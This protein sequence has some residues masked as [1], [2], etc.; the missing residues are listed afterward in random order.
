MEKLDICLNQQK[1]FRKLLAKMDYERFNESW[2]FMNLWMWWKPYNIKAVFENDMIACVMHGKEQEWFLRPIAMKK[3]LKSWFELTKRIT[4]LEFTI[5]HNAHEELIDAFKGHGLKVQV[6]DEDVELAE[7]FYEADTFRNYAGKKLQKKRNLVNRFKKDH[8]GNWEFRVLGKGDIPVVQE[9]TKKWE[10][11]N[12]KDLEYFKV[13]IQ[14][15]ND[16]LEDL[17]Q[18]DDFVFGGIFIGGKIEGFSLGE[19][20]GDDFININIEKANSDI[21]GL[22][23]VLASEFLKKAAPNVKYVSR[24]D[25]ADDDGLKKSKMSY[26]PIKVVKKYDII[27]SD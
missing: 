14:I 20:V 11:H 26:R 22:Y 17:N 13:E 1:T 21:I 18:F 27:I 6:S 12:F 23:Q 25:A 16:L 7:Y 5:I 4:G 3:D 2:N 15:V 9:F 8:E 10:R 24:E 19:R